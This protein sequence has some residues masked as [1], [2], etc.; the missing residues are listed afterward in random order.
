[1]F[2]THLRATALIFSVILILK[3]PPRTSQ[4]RQ[5]YETSSSSSTSSVTPVLHTQG[6]GKAAGRG[7]I[8]IRKDSSGNEASPNKPVEIQFENL[9][10]MGPQLVPGMT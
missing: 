3:M 2:C 8:T 9:S 5:S 6:H 4:T 10:L 7:L 1:M